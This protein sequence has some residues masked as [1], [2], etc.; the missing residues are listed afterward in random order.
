[1]LAAVLAHIV[2]GI[3]VVLGLY[4][5]ITFGADGL[6]LFPASQLGVYTLALVGVAIMAPVRTWGYAIAALCTGTIGWWLMLAALE[7]ET[8]EFFTAPPA[9]ILFLIGLWRLERR[10]EAG[11]WSAL[12]LPILAGIGPSLLLALNEGDELRR[13]G[14]GAAAIA[15][16]IAGLVRRWQAP[17]VLGS[18]VLAV[19]VVNELL[20]LRGS[21]PVWIPPAIGGAIL[22]AVGATFERRRRDLR[23]IREGLKSMR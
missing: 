14:V 6:E 20:L 15:V 12:A 4:A 22:I 13:V 3:S 10:P 8:L 2:A 7:V 17:L 23:R 1:M 11:S 19:M 9:A 16:I 18:I 5:G 21:I